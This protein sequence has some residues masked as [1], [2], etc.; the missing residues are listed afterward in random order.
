MSEMPSELQLDALREVANV[1][2]GHAAAALSRLVGGRKV[3]I[4]VPRV[5]F[6]PRSELVGLL[7]EKA[8]PLWGTIFRL[9][10]EMSGQLVLALT[11]EDARLLCSLLLQMPVPGPLEELHWS[12]LTEAANI[13]ASACLNAMGRLAKLRLLPSTPALIQGG[14]L[15]L[16]EQS[17]SESV[18]PSGLVMALEARFF[19][20]AAPLVGGQL[21]VLPDPLGLSTLLARL[22]V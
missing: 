2:C 4:T 16:L 6:A 22:G 9:E 17:L 21:L 18:S 1:G 5:A 12:A 14:P 10:G 11:E 20:A 3:Q 8:A 7:G 19:T 15:Q 13:L